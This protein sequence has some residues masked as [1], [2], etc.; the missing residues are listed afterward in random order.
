MEEDNLRNS[1]CEENKNK[2]S[3]LQ[4][5][6]LRNSIVFCL[7][8]ASVNLSCLIL[9]ILFPDSFLSSKYDSYIL[10]WTIA[11]VNLFSVIISISGAIYFRNQFKNLKENS[12]GEIG[13]SGL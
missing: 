12:G 7:F 4:K 13:C 6:G 9:I 5:K 8:T 1:F 10:L 2:W 11:G 3:S